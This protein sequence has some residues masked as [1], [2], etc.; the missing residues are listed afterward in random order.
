MIRTE[1]GQT[2]FRADS[3]SEL[4]ADFSCI[5]K[6]LKDFFMEDEGMQEEQAEEEIRK[7]VE[8]ALAFKDEEIPEKLDEL[9]GMILDLLKGGKAD[10]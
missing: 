2:K 6:S 7:E 5:V 10:E 4:K 8:N 9:L 1:Y 3:S